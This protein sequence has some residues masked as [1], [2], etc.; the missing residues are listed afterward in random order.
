MCGIMP[1]MKTVHL[2]L[3]I[4]VLLIISL[5]VISCPKPETSDHSQT[6]RN[7]PP[8]TPQPPAADTDQAVDNSALDFMEKLGFGRANL[9]ISSR[10]LMPEKS[11]LRWKLIIED[12]V[13]MFVQLIVNENTKRVV[14]FSLEGRSL[15]DL[16]PTLQP[17]EGFPERIGSALGLESDGYKPIAWNKNFSFREYR[18][19]ATMGKWE[20]S[21]AKVIIFASAD[22]I[23]PIMINF[24]DGEL[25]A[26]TEVLLDRETAISKAASFSGKS[27]IAPINVELTQQRHMP[28]GPTDF[29]I[30][31][32]VSYGDLTVHVKA[33]D[34]SILEDP[35][36]QSMPPQ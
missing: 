7:N 26:N 30:Y 32:E 24:T 33:D 8:A 9:R 27:D 21:V 16:P 1:S 28:Y 18:K 12:N 15:I 22:P 23:S 25:V 4:L 35:N 3:P 19:Y 6:V 14:M 34:G 36:T 11:A 17:G 20:I 5:S 13:G 29:S 31:W 2:I 10:V